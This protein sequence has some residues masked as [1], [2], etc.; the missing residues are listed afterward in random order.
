MGGG[1]AV[2]REL[3]ER[4]QEVPVQRG[5]LTRAIRLK[6]GQDRVGR[7]LLTELDLGHSDESGVSGTLSSGMTWASSTSMITF[8]A[9]M[10][11]TIWLL[12]CASR[13]TCSD[14]RPITFMVSLGEVA[15]QLVASIRPAAMRWSAYAILPVA[16]SLTQASLKARAMRA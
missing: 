15:A 11:R 14:V 3:V 7:G 13:R 2:E 4:P 6:E 16:P 8:A 12:S 10:P 5:Q 9:M 1:C